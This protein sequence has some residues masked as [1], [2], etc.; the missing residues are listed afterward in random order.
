[1]IKDHIKK[2]R[3]HIFIGAL[4]CAVTVIFLLILFAGRKTYTVTF[5]LN[6]GELISGVFSNDSVSQLSH[7]IGGVVGCM[8]G[9]IFI[10]RRG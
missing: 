6:G 8:F 2:Y 10:P 5:D 9:Y 1:M 4:I 7:V 3:L